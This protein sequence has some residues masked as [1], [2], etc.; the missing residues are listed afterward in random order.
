VAGLDQPRH[1][2]GADVARHSGDQQAHRS[3]APL[4]ARRKNAVGAGSAVR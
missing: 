3:R 2:R 4:E 1:Q